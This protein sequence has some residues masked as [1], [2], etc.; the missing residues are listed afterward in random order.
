MKKLSII[1]LFIFGAAGIVCAQTSGGRSIPST[2]VK[3]VEGKTVST[4]TFSNN[5]KPIIVSF[6]ATWCKPCKKEL[7]A[8]AEQYEEW[9]EQTG[10][11]LIAI[12][13]DDSRS[14][15]K[16]GADVR[17]K[18]WKYDIYIDENQDFKR[19]MSVNNVPHTFI[20]DGKGNIVW[21]HNSYAE[22]DEEALF[23]AVKKV[24]KGEKIT[25]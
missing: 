1:T 19:A 8:I 20:V 21:Q 15:S 18:G 12:S 6:W 4:S 5:G 25:E 23:E 22:G 9:V 16:V 11:K 14:V 10:V 24:A 13:I 17:S 3:T 2:D 7:D